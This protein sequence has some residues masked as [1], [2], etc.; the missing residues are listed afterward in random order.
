M[1]RAGVV[2]VERLRMALTV[3]L[4][5]AYQAAAKINQGELLI[6]S[7]GLVYVVR[8]GALVTVLVQDGRHNHGMDL[9]RL[10]RAA[11]GDGES[12]DVG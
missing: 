2:D 12:S 8:E 10:R 6:L 9:A 7:E 5:R 11:Q 1:D 4:D 3:A